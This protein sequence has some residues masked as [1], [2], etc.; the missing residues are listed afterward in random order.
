MVEQGPQPRRAAGRPRAG[1][2]VREALVAAALNQL[3]ASGGSESVTVAAIVAEARCT[4]PALYHYWPTREQLLMEASSRGWDQFRASQAQSVQEQADPLTRL[5]LR[6][7]GYLD[8][9]L[10]RP[11][12]F[13][14]LF[15][16]PTPGSP[17]ETSRT[18]E[19]RA[20][21]DLVADVQAAIE[22]G[23]L[24]PREPLIVAL[25]LWSAMHGVAALWA[26]D[27]Q[28]PAELAVAAGELAQ[29]AILLG[30]AS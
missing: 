21:R 27:P 19:G 13:R 12:L 29:D 25:S 9:A 17:H 10:A 8:F 4:A 6:G 3:L 5:R 7:R 11:A 14:V 24:A 1:V 28:R 16:S 2:D 26:I 20:F 30:L 22:Q 18:P 23:Q 15:M